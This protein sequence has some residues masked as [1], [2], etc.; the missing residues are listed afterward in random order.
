MSEGR[1]P[2]DV[3]ITRR[4]ARQ[5]LRN[6]R[7]TLGLDLS[8]QEI[9]D[10]LDDADEEQA[11]IDRR[12]GFELR[13]RDLSVSGPVGGEGGLLVTLTCELP[14]SSVALSR[15]RMAYAAGTRLWVRIIPWDR[16]RA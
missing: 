1:D 8:D 9:E 3:P 10:R 2:R 5:S 4:Q 15:L 11:A 12:A 14:A 6:M 13:L 16:P 7:E